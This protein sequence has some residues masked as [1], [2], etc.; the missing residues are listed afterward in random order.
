M[1]EP[2]LGLVREED[3]F[4]FQDYYELSCSRADWS[5]GH[6]VS[7]THSLFFRE[8]PWEYGAFVLNVGLEQ[9]I[10]AILKILES[11]QNLEYEFFKDTS[12][13]DITEEFL[14]YLSKDKPKLNVWAIPEGQVVFPREPLIIVEGNTIWN[15]FFET[16]LLS[17]MNHQCAVATTA[18]RIR[19]ACGKRSFIDFGARRALSWQGGLLGA[20]AA[21]IGG[22]DAT[23][24]V[25]A[26]L[27]FNIPYTGT[28]HHSFIQS[29]HHPDKPFSRSELEAFT[30]YAAVYPHNTL[31]VVDTYNTISGAMNAIEV[32]KRLREENQTLR[33]V[34]LDSGNQQKL[35]KD[36][37]ML[38]NSNGMVEAKIYSSDGMEEGKIQK[39]REDGTP[40]DGFGVGTKLHVGKPSL[41][42]VYKLVEAN[43][44]PVMKFS[45]NFKKA[46][47]PGKQQVWR[48]YDPRGQMHEDFISCWD[49]ELKSEFADPLLVQ[50]I[51][52]GKLIYNFPT[53]AEIKQTARENLSRVKKGLKMLGR[54]AP[55][56]PVNLS[57]GLEVMRSSLWAKYQ[58]E[59]Q[60]EKP[61]E[62]INEE[63]FERVMKLVDER[64]N[65][66]AQMRWKHTEKW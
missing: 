34:R 64:N 33:G 58:A 32:G 56:Y 26:G 2:R 6:V 4:L 1:K 65:I 45:D 61:V 8:I 20:R 49:E 54:G 66:E 38:L 7:A 60:G 47:L 41:G 36:V 21:Y 43:D 46:T 44:F 39:F 52:N 50:I 42:M 22:A 5:S 11:P 16:L 31:P 15:T 28:M 9:S 27:E 25:L 13:G 17:N 57:P 29:R 63:E 59:Y 40:I 35:S 12:S 30:H 48:V 19:H 18:A 53:T 37:R 51:E 55:I 10:A 62:K 14:D 3:L 23:S 24:L